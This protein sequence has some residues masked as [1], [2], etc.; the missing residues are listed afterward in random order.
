MWFES[1]AADG[2]HHSVV[3]S[4]TG[5]DWL[6]EPGLLLIFPGFVFKRSSVGRAPDC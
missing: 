6:Y 4:T 5:C 3:W 2:L 1:T